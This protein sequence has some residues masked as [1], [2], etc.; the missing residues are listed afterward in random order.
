MILMVNK[1]TYGLFYKKKND[2]KKKI[3]YSPLSIFWPP[4][5]A[6]VILANQITSLQFSVPKIMSTYSMVS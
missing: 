4:Q 6:Y 3:Q 1:N 5:N 2:F